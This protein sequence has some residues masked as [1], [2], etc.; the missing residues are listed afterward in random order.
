MSRVLLVLSLLVSSVQAQTL[1]Y[2]RSPRGLP[3]NIIAGPD[4]N[5]WF[6]QRAF[7]PLGSD[8]VSGLTRVT[9]L[10]EMTSYAAPHAP[11]YRPGMAAWPA[12]AISFSWSGGVDSLDVATGTYTSYP[13]PVEAETLLAGPD[14]NLWFGY[15]GGVGGMTRSGAITLFPLDKRAGY[16]VPDVT[17]LTVGADGNIWFADWRAHGF[18]TMNLSGQVLK[19]ADDYGASSIATASDGT[20]WASGLQW[21]GRIKADYKVDFVTL[22]LLGGS[23]LPILQRI[24]PGPNGTVW[25]AAT[26][27]IGAASADGSVKTFLLDFPYPSDVVLGPD[28]NIWAVFEVSYSCVT[29]CFIDPTP[30]IALVRVNLVNPAPSITNIDWSVNGVTIHGL[31]F[32]PDTIVRFN[33]A[34]RATTYVSPFELVINAPDASPSGTFIAVNRAPGGGA[35]APF[36]FTGRALGRRRAAR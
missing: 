3:M 4:G 17:G 21:L 23:F 9:P 31:G 30:P 7:S 15:Y 2:F 16:G 35:S 6:A 20:V 26:Q 22:P 8:Q 12:G 36:V 24:T 1:S 13:T 18:G 27:T 5:L 29:P 33:G 14:G 28:G 10:G 19:Y 25:Y 34:D 11:R 32:V